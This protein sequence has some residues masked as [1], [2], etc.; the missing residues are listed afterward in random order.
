MYVLGLRQQAG[1][2]S[3]GVLSE[4]RGECTALGRTGSRVLRLRNMS[5]TGVR[6]VEVMFR[7]IFELPSIVAD[8]TVGTV[9]VLMQLA[10]VR[11]RDSVTR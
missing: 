1:A 4:S 2:L 8:Y 3:L 10:I 11:R 7:N 9:I 6:Y 5:E